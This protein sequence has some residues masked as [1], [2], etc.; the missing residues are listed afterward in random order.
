MLSGTIGTTDPDSHLIRQHLIQ[1]GTQRDC[2]VTSVNNSGVDVMPTVDRTA[3]ITDSTVSLSHTLVRELGITLVP[4]RV[5]LNN[6]T[7]RDGIDITPMQVYQHL[8]ASGPIPTTAAPSPGDFLQAFQEAT[9]TT[10]HILCLTLSS[11]LSA[12][13]DAAIS[14]ANIMRN[15]CPGLEIRVVDSGTAAGAQTI[16]AVLAARQARVGAQLNKIEALIQ[17]SKRKVYMLAMMDT[18]YFAAKGG[19]VPRPVAWIGNLLQ[20]KPVL[21]LQP[22][23]NI[24]LLARPRTRG[25]AFDCL[26]RLTDSYVSGSEIIVNI[27]HA[28]ASEDAATL[29]KYVEENYS[30]TEVFTTEMSPVIGTHTGPGLV[31]LA[32]CLNPYDSF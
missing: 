2:Q 22:E 30:C 9:T 23:G 21:G 4:M 17:N 18:L 12:T 19:R 28:D 16:L 11:R 6:R 14:A 32:F 29:K 8:R 27:V 1:I 25:R 7:Y 10:N 15:R 31:G 3:I 5:I 24:R 13:Y 20:I 26:L